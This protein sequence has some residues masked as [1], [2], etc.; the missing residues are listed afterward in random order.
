MPILF[1]VSTVHYSVRVSDSFLHYFC[2][3]CPLSLGIHHHFSLKSMQTRRSSSLSDIDNTSQSL[4]AFSDNKNVHAL[5]DFLLNYRWVH[6]C[7]QI[8][9]IKL[10]GYILLFSFVS[11]FLF[12]IF[13]RSFLTFLTASDVPVLYSPVPFQNAALSAPEV[14]NMNFL[15]YHFFRAKLFLPQ[16]TALFPV[17]KFD[18]L[19]HIFL[20]FSCLAM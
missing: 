14:G 9:K 15:L 16:F 18:L 4:L 3:D 19:F 13:F 5:Y 6:I 2:W 10:T 7:F 17:R 1:I 12:V 8:V 11:D 20:H